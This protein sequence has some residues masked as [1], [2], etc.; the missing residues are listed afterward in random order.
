MSPTIVAAAASAALSMVKPALKF[1]LSLVTR[2]LRNAKAD[3]LIRFTKATRVEPIVMIDQRVAHLPYMNDVMQ[4]LSSIFIGYYLQAVA[5][6][7]NVG[8]INVI[9]LLDTLNP[10]RDVTDA[11]AT[12]IVDTINTPSFNSMESYQFGLPRLGAEVS[13]EAQVHAGKPPIGPQGA[14][15]SDIG[16]VAKQGGDVGATINNSLQHGQLAD[17]MQQNLT[18]GLDKSKLVHLHTD[19]SEIN[20]GGKISQGHDLFGKDTLKSLGEAVNL[21]VGKLVEVNVSDNGASAT[22]PISIRLIATIVGSS[23]LAHILGDGSRN[24][25]AKERY[26]AW[27]AGQ[28]EFWRDLVLCQDLIDEHKR[29]LLKDSTGVYDQIL[30][31]RAGNTA[32]GAIT[33]SPSIG[34]ASNLLVLS[35]QTAHELELSI[36]GKLSDFHVRQKVLES[37]YIMLLVV[38]DPQWEQVTIYHRGIA[39]PTQLSIKELKVSNKNTGPDVGEILKAYQLGQNPTI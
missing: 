8:R 39:L 22:F 33:G 31:R 19:V 1:T 34:T 10:S 12:K 26:H 24:T 16:K 25:S 17:K 27:R 9:R 6:A 23:I 2:V 35:K 18:G 28:L 29:T 30:K 32:A 38:V 13:M 20:A 15:I 37:T 7:V 21:S 11:A 4:T 14:T 5:L 3:S 36:R